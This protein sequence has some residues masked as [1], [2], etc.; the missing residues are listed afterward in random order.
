MELIPVGAADEAFLF[1]V[2][3]G[4]RREEVAGWGWDAAQQES[5]LQMQFQVQRRAYQMQY[6]EA[7]HCIIVHDGRPV[8]RTIV[9]RTTNGL[10]LV[11]IAVLPEYRGAGIGTGVLRTLQAQAALAGQPLRLHVM[12]ANPARRLYERLGFTLTGEND[13]H[14]A[15]EWRPGAER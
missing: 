9:Q 4:T 1:Q 11:D 12:R 3:A 10:H 15:M 6:E 8:G 14:Y 2:Y 13:T 7:E 5:F